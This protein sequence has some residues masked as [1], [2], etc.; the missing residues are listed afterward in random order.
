MTFP[1]VAG[2]A[3]PG[4]AGDNTTTVNV[5]ITGAVAG[6]VLLV[7]AGSEGTPGWSTPSGWTQLGTV[8][9]NSKK[10]WLWGKVAA[11]SD[12]LVVDRSGASASISLAYYRL[13]DVVGGLAGIEVATNS[14][15]GD[16]DPPSVTA[17]W[18]LADNLFICGK[19]ANQS[20]VAAWP[21]SYSSNQL[22]SDTGGGGY[23]RTVMANRQL[24]AATDNPSAFSDGGS[25]G[26]SFTAV[27]RGS[28]ASPVLAGDVSTDAALPTGT[29]TSL[30]ASTLTG[31]IT[32]TDTAPT[33]TLGAVPG[34][35]TT[36][37]WK[38]DAGDPQPLLTV[39]LMTFLRRFD[40]VQVL[41]LANQV[42][43]SSPT[44]PVIVVSNAALAAGTVYMVAS[45]NA[46]GTLYGIEP[47]LAA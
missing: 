23:A 14:N 43:T 17:S 26:L 1:T 16:S 8:T 42:T 37:P 6:Q 32:T 44:A 12:T 38:N 34:T 30:A 41:T 25:H 18:G 36:Q 24:A 7:W 9:G 21:T 22:D 11:G 39:P 10:A 15:F 2:A 40:G 31:T 35:I 47:C 27:V 5:T 28:V 19:T 20:S 13:A 29:L 45:W 4:G 46:D 33:G 3:T